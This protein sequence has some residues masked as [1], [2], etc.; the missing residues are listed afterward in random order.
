MKRITIISFV[1]L[2]AGGGLGS[3]CLKPKTSQF[4]VSN[5]YIE[6]ISEVKVGADEVSFSDIEKQTSSEYRTIK[7]GNYS[8]IATSGSGS[9]F[10]TEL[11]IESRKSG[12]FTLLIDGIGRVSIQNDDK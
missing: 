4:R 7:P 3:G 10:N 5:Y 2:L 6:R 1:A 11:K 8:V 12:R 9:K